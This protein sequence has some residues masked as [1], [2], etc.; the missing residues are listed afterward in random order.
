MHVQFISKM[1][2]KEAKRTGIQL[3]MNRGVIGLIFQL[4]HYVTIL[5]IILFIAVFTAIT[6]SLMSNDE[7]RN[8]GIVKSSNVE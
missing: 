6:F 3:Q 7:Q 2:E 1:M 8:F 5:P 4:S